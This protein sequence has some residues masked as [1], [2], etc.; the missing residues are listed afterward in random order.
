MFYYPRL[1]SKQA[2]FFPFLKKE[3]KVARRVDGIYTLNSVLFLAPNVR[4][5]PPLAGQR[6]NKTRK[7]EAELG[8]QGRKKKHKTLAVERG[9]CSK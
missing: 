1:G 7:A 9:L 2:I 6:K 8:Q 3:G 4:K 5:A